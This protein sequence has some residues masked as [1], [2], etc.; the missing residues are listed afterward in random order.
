M[1]VELTVSFSSP[2]IFFVSAPTLSRTSSHVAA[3]HQGANM[4]VRPLGKAMTA[5]IHRCDKMR[6]ARKPLANMRDL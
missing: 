3:R 6:E 4:F 1:A 5:H 2:L